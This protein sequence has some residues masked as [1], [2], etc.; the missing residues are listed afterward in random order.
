[1]A[2]ATIALPTDTLDHPTHL[3]LRYTN[4]QCCL[5]LRYRFLYR[6]TNNMQ[7]V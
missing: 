6:L 1:M 5:L 2:D 3:T 7:S 4:H